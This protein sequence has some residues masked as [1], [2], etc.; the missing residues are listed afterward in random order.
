MTRWRAGEPPACHNDTEE[1]QVA[2]SL[3]VSRNASYLTGVTCLWGGQYSADTLLTSTVII[4]KHYFMSRSSQSVEHV[5]VSC[6]LKWV[7]TITFK[8]F[9]LDVISDKHQ[10]LKC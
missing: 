7:F 9:I 3:L 1:R 10:T 2:G 5:A 8:V 6:V 4:Y